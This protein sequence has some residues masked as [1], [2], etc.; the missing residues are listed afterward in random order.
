VPQRN[1]GVHVTARSEV[2]VLPREQDRH[3]G[4]CRSLSYEGLRRVW[5]GVPLANGHR[6]Q[7]P[8]A[9]QSPF[10]HD[11]LAV[12][13][14]QQLPPASGGSPHAPPGV[15]GQL[16]PAPADPDQ[17]RAGPSQWRTL[18]G[19]R[20]R[21]ND[22]GAGVHHRDATTKDFALGGFLGSIERAR[23]EADKCVLVCVNCHRVR[24][25]IA[26]TTSGHAV[27]R[28]RRN[29]KLR[30]VVA[31]GGACRGC[32]LG[33]PV[34]ALEFHHL[35][36]KTKE[37]AISVDGIPRGW[38][39]IEAE[40]AKCVLLCANCHRETHAGLRTFTSDPGVAEAAAAYRAA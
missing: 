5:H 12:R 36:P 18:R 2:R 4:A 35:D 29:V 22:L 11:L 7:A 23:A 34:D 24:H 10:L 25:A 31:L 9:Q 13:R 19:L 8:V 30:C 21:A 1:L 37:F 15:M 32:G 20:L 14:A 26:K 27:V 6:R 17:G 28:S 39:K 3:A 16:Q 33:S 40:L 38:K